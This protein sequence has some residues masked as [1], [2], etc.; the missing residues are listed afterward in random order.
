MS[1]RNISAG[2]VVNAGTEIATISD[3]SSI[4]L[5]FSV[6]ETLLPAVRPGLTIEARSAAYPDQPFR[7]QVATIDP[8]VDPNT[9]AAMVRA[10]SAARSSGECQTAS[11]GSPE[12]RSAINSA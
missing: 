8:V 12:S 5:D 2:A 9:R 11:S 3:V 7:G 10:V 1:L 4:K 6:P